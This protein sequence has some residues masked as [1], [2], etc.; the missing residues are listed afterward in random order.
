MVSVCDFRSQNATQLPSSVKVGGGHRDETSIQ[1]PADRLKFLSVSVS[2]SLP[3]VW[4]TAYHVGTHSK[5]K[6]A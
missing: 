6:D 4:V 1:F 2:G 5:G 3:N